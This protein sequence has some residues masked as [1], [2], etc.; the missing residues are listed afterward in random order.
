MG[1]VIALLI[2]AIVAAIFGFGGF[3]S[4]IASMAVILFWVFLALFVIGLMV[5]AVRGSWWW[6]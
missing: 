4:T 1:L 6:W 2:L 5:R 3:A